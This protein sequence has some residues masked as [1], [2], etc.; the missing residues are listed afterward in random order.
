MSE[1]EEKLKKLNFAS[2][3]DARELVDLMQRQNQQMERTITDLRSVLSSIR[4]ELSLTEGYSTLEAIRRL[5][6]AAA[7]SETINPK[8]R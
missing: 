5:K 4:K 7:V 1:L 3:Q 6:A 2:M 8:K